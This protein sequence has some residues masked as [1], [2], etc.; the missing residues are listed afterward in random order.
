MKQKKYLKIVCPNLA[1]PEDVFSPEQIEEQPSFVE[2][3]RDQEDKDVV[4]FQK[5]GDK[6]I[7]EKLY[8][9]RIPTLQIW[10]R[11]YF[12]LMDSKED[13]FGELSHYFYKAIINYE[14]N[15]GSF[16]TCLYTFLIYHIRNL[17]IGKNAKKRLPLFMDGEINKYNFMLSLEYKYNDKNG[18][19][20][21]LKDVIPDSKNKPDD[22]LKKMDLEETVSYL[23]HGSPIV[24][25]FLR[26]ISDGSTLASALKEYKTKTGFISI[27]RRLAKKIEDK[28]NCKNLVKE[29]IKDKVN[30]DR[31]ALIDYYVGKYNKLCY[32]IEMKKT[33]EANI[34]LKA[35]RRFRKNKEMLESRIIS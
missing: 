24:K 5:T 1:K 4:L 18:S 27:G 29:I 28:R 11:Q 30:V 15:K 10:A 17:H 20:N 35:I 13:M 23:S 33:Q 16:N 31:F 22:T 19:V 2:I 32:T 8:K 9:N 14:K 3:D 25:G 12:Y 6:E 21:T 26:K 34:I 7:F